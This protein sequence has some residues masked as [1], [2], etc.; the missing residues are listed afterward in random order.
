[1]VKIG[2]RG[3]KKVP[4]SV[5]EAYANRYP[6]LLKSGV[7]EGPLPPGPDEKAPKK[8]TFDPENPRPDWKD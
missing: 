2:G 1:M 5:I 6:S 4:R 8:E 7:L 3:I